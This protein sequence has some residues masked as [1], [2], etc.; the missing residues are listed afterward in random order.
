MQSRRASFCVIESLED[1]ARFCD[2]GAMAPKRRRRTPFL[3]LCNANTMCTNSVR[4]VN[5]TC[6]ESRHRRAPRFGGAL[7][8][9][10]S[11]T[12]RRQGVPAGRQ[13]GAPPPPRAAPRL[14]CTDPRSYAVK[15]TD[16]RSYSN[17]R[18]RA[19]AAPRGRAPSRRLGR[20]LHGLADRAR[21]RER[22]RPLLPVRII[23]RPCRQYRPHLVVS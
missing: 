19:A 22:F 16:P 10:G 23:S 2:C 9:G 3:Q 13:Q 20:A 1:R 7:A 14:L 6:S 18:T 12:C 17:S 11:Q 15:C 5:I 4:N 8:R 21:G